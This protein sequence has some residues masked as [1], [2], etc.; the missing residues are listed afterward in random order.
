[1]DKGPN[2]YQVNCDN[3]SGFVQNA[4]D[5]TLYAHGVTHF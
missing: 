2:S 1:M 5:V 3:Q 4:Q